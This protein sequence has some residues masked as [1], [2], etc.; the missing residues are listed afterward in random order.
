MVFFRYVHHKTWLTFLSLRL[1][2]KSKTIHCINWFNFG[3]EQFYLICYKL[4]WWGSRYRCPYEI[5]NQKV[6][7]PVFQVQTLQGRFLKMGNGTL[8]LFGKGYWDHA[9]QSDIWWDYRNCAGT[10]PGQMPALI[11]LCWKNG[12]QNK[13]SCYKRGLYHK[14]MTGHEKKGTYCLQADGSE[15]RT[16]EEP[17]GAVR[18]RLFF[19]Y[20]GI[21]NVKFLYQLR[22]S[23]PKENSERV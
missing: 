17:G 14:E 21:I 3:T 10:W 2:S 11:P 20:F 19:I 5:L 12:T 8:L 22:A 18:A 6:R 4:N 15:T 13:N 16:L 9:R 7:K 23:W 1:Q